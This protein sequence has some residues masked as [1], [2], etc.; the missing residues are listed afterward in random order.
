MAYYL[1][2]HITYTIVYPMDLTVILMRSRLVSIPTPTT[3]QCSEFLGS[4]HH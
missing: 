2:A 3:M 4:V 1:N